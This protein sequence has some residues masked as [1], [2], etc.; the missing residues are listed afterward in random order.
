MRNFLEG[1][2]IPK[3]RMAHICERLILTTNIY[4]SHV[5]AASLCLRLIRQDLIFE[6]S[7]LD[8]AMAHMSE[9]LLH[10]KLLG[11]IQNRTAPFSIPA[12]Y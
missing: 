9:R 2:L 11:T 6:Y 7:K 8:R 5:R 10:T 3:G 12:A 4:S 1:L